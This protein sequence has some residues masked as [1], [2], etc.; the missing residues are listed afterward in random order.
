MV[1]DKEIPPHHMLTPS[2]LLPDGPPASSMG[3]R[4]WLPPH[5]APRLSPG[6]AS[7]GRFVLRPEIPWTPASS[8]TLDPVWSSP[9][10]PSWAPLAKAVMGKAGD[11]TSSGSQP[12]P[13]LWRDRREEPWTGH[14]PHWALLGPREEG[15]RG[16]APAGRA[17]GGFL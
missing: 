13:R 7:S 5:P 6:P 11:G 14:E 2:S 9:L 17:G 16:R 12:I 8:L 4:A 1:Q 10:R 3:V 15:P